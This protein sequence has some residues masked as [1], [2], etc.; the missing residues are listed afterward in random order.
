MVRQGARLP[1]GGQAPPRVQEMITARL[2]HLGSQSYQLATIASVIGRPFD[3]ALLRAASGLGDLATAEAVEELTRRG[4]ITVVGTQLDFTHDRIRE[5]LR[6]ALVPPVYK[7][8]HL[9]VARAIEQVYADDLRPHYGLLAIHFWEGEDWPAAAQRFEEAGRRALSSAA[10]HAASRFF[11]SAL[12]ALARLPETRERM[13]QT[14]EIRFALRDALMPVGNLSEARRHLDEADILSQRL[15]D[16]RRRG[17]VAAYRADYALQALDAAQAVSFGETGLARAEELDDARLRRLTHSLL[18]NA[19]FDLGDYRRAIAT[20]KASLDEASGARFP[21]L[22]AT[23]ACHIY[24]A[25][26]FMQLGEWAQARSAL[27]DG[28]EWALQEGS[29]YALVRTIYGDGVIEMNAYR[30]D[31]AIPTLEQGLAIAREH[32]LELLIPHFLS[33]LGLSYA[34]D[35]RVGEGLP[36]LDDAVARAEQLSIRR[37]QSVHEIRRA[38]ACLLAGRL[39]D[40]TRS[41]EAALA[42]VRARRERGT[43]GWALRIQGEIALARR[44]HQGAQTMFRDALEIATTLE[45]RRLEGDC[46]L[47][48]GHSLKLAG[49][50]HAA[51]AELTSARALFQAMELV[52]KSTL[53]RSLFS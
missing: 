39:D 15:G 16:Q 21:D 41:A 28:R 9:A 34:L 11:G 19:Y 37:W 5:V 42:L 45:M 20:T 7:A 10:M 43:E 17:Y 33:S 4:V 18:A 12:D 35:G 13:E 40:A 36:L 53:A 49:D 2:R 46:R 51:E 26:S 27:R 23:V 30:P 48:L 31:R 1:A 50:M 38:E 47:G 3:F 32:E 24:L 29:P 52:P 25:V 8:L 22:M 14:I 44:D 6:L